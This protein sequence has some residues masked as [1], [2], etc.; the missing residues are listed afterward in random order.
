M[1]FLCISKISG[2]SKF[3]FY[4][5]SLD[6]QVSS[7]YLVKASNLS[8]IPS[9]YHKFANIFNKSKS[10]VLTSYYLYNLRINLEEDSQPL[11]GTI[12]FLSASK[13][14]TLK[15]F[16]EENLNIYFIQPIYFLYSI[17]VLFVKKKDELLYLCVDFHS[18]NYITKKDC[19]S[20][21]LISGL[22]NSLCKA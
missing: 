8:N 19:Y 15:E 20:L 2:F 11:V 22:L 16:I 13:Q 7:A 9:K 12:Y 6:I 3:Q 17:L 21:P 14:E 18:L 1:V 5:H 10:E 4:L